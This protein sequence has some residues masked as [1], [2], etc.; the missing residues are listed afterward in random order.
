[1]MIRYFVVIVK[2]KMKVRLGYDDLGIFKVKKKVWV[3]FNFCFLWFIVGDFVCIV[4]WG[5]CFFFIVE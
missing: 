5:G 1:M 2:N 4:L 3:L